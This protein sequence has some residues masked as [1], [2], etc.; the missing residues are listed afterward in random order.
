M[1]K[2]LLCM[3]TCLLWMLEVHSQPILI[4]HLDDKTGLPQNSIKGLAFDRMGY[5]W[6]G[7]EMG[8]SRYD[9]RHLKNYYLPEL[10]SGRVGVIIKDQKSE[11]IKVQTSTADTIDIA[12][13]RILSIGTTFGKMGMDLSSPLAFIYHDS[14]GIQHSV[15][16]ELSRTI[17]HDNNGSAIKKFVPAD[18]SLIVP[19]GNALYSIDRNFSIQPRPV[20]SEYG[21]RTN[22]KSVDPSFYAPSNCNSRDHV[23]VVKD[24]KIYSLSLHDNK[25]S[26]RLLM[27]KVP[28]DERITIALYEP[29]YQILCL[30]T[31]TEGL[32]LFRINESF[33]I[34]GGTLG[35]SINAHIL[36]DKDHVFASGQLFSTEGHKRFPGIDP[37]LLPSFILYKDHHNDILFENVREEIARLNPASGTIEIILPNQRAECISEDKYNRLWL[38]DNNDGLMIYDNNA[39]KPRLLKQ[40]KHLTSLRGTVVEDKN[41]KGFWMIAGNNTLY[42]FNSDIELTDSFSLGGKQVIRSIYL[43]PNGNIWA[44]TYGDGIYRFSGKGFVSMPPDRM[45]YLQYAHCIIEDRSGYFWISTNKG[46]FRVQKTE[47][48]A[49]NPG[50]PLPA[51]YYFNHTDGLASNEFNGACFPC[52]NQDRDGSFSFPTMKGVVYFNPE[53]IHIRNIQS[54]VI[55]DEIY[56][57]GRKVVVSDTM[58]IGNDIH[59][60]SF[61]VSIPYWGNEENLYISYIMEGF[62]K[63]W[64]SLPESNTV[65]YT[66]IPSGRHRLI[67]RI[68]DIEHSGKY[69]YTTLRLVVEKKFYQTW[70]FLGLLFLALVT[71]IMA[72]SGFRNLRLKKKNRELEAAV[73]AR[74]L[75]LLGSNQKLEENNILLEK[76]QKSLN[77]SI[78]L[79]DKAMAIFSHNIIGP[80][81]YISVVTDAISKNVVKDE[82]RY[83]DDVNMTSK[84]LLIQSIELLNWLNTQKEQYKVEIKSR[85]IY[86]LCEEKC[87][88]FAPIANYKGLRIVNS[89][90]HKTHQRIDEQLFGVIMYNL[91][92]N[93][94]KYTRSGTIQVSM[95]EDEQRWILIVEDSGIGMSPE[96]LEQFNAPPDLP[97][98]VIKSPDDLS[99]GLGWNIII[100][101]LKM[102]DAT[103]EISSR[104]NEGTVI[105]LLFRK[106]SGI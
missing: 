61:N 47:M 10:H 1:A 87:N 11:H 43:A 98:A 99:Y 72:Y 6:I 18:N 24:K 25:L 32:Y 105:S 9:G 78:L 63:T 34:A 60:V 41:R 3:L 91:L 38:I 20:S 92:D 44:S 35:R 16:R 81:K 84:N 19:V 101:C 88:M 15:G 104:E 13:G 36:L 50:A 89:I 94:I 75:E 2:Q 42:F 51:F 57:D 52:A 67:F 14:L 66:E 73:T 103:Y 28:F 74:S 27:D 59:R 80:I 30:G 7:T 62:D 97:R 26:V 23:L 33:S 96:Q 79:K 53:K 71:L 46:L 8:I 106:V 37:A 55:M 12:D 29:S 82:K 69:H 90:P 70:W 49:Y 17:I 65:N 102:L 76:K 100:D 21:P 4:T 54:P 85:N 93:A 48:D 77:R 56:F 58:F 5:L 40:L 68:R 39:R 64:Q 95:K 31:L 45:K 83:L 86:K 22:G